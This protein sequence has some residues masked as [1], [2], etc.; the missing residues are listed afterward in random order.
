MK[1]RQQTVTPGLN[2]GPIRAQRT[3]VAKTL[4]HAT[5]K[6]A[7]IGLKMAL[8]LLDEVLAG[9]PAPK[10]KR[11]SAGRANM[12]LAAYKAH[13]TMIMRQLPGTRGKAREA[14]KAKLAQYEARIA[15]A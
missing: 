3:R 13:R 1:A 15:A 8:E 10:A 14:L 9:A 5:N 11:S 12:Q 6:V 2:Y 7:I 4:R